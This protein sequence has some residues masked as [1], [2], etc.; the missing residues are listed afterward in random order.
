MGLMRVEKSIISFSRRNG[1]FAST[2]WSKSSCS[3]ERSMR[4]VFSDGFCIKYVGTRATME[5][6]YH[7]SLYYFLWRSRSFGNSPILAGLAF[8]KEFRMTPI[9]ALISVIV[10]QHVNKIHVLTGES[11]WTP[12]RFRNGNLVLFGN[13]GE[14]GADLDDWPPRRSYDHLGFFLS[15]SDSVGRES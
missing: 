3:V 14:N 1:C 12:C 7:I 8:N 15:C 11:A 13:A 5:I 4:E 10:N 2:I 6:F 9:E